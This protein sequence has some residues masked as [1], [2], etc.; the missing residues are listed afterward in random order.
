[1]SIWDHTA[2]QTPGERASGYTPVL[3]RH[4]QTVGIETV[5]SFG[6]VVERTGQPQGYIFAAGFTPEANREA[7]ECFD[8]TGKRIN[9]V[10]V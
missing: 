4:G 7:V 3:P 10:E 9:L 2:G 8:R 5:R 1:M 6:E